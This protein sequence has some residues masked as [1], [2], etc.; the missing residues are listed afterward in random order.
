MSWASLPLDI[1]A[2]GGR[3][4]VLNG[5]GEERLDVFLRAKSSW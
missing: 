4:G 5:F 2:L 1:N 3:E